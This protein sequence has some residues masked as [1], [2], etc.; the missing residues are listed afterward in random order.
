M[1]THFSTSGRTTTPDLPPATNEDLLQL[2]YVSSAVE[3]WT[4]RE[5]V[6]GLAKFR[7]NNVRNGITG[8]LLYHEG[9]FM[10]VIEGPGAAIQRLRKTIAA[11][12]RHHGFICLLERKISGRE[13]SG[14]SMG[15]Q[16][17][18]TT[19]L[20]SL[21]GWSG[22]LG[23]S[24]VSDEVKRSPGLALKLLQTFRQNTRA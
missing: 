19:E 15:F 3:P 12:P 14:W 18:T 24:F 23:H 20:A 13:F 7:A 11:D 1:S 10:Q 16:R 17:V 6:E 5:L 22:F 8:M 21:P 2:V 9:N 4:D